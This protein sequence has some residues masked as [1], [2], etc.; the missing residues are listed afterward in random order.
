MEQLLTFANATSDDGHLLRRCSGTPQGCVL[1]R[2]K[3]EVSI[4]HAFTRSRFQGELAGRC[5]TFQHG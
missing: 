1:P 3:V 4:S 5:H 2:R